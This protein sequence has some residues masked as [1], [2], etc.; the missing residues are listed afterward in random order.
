MRP[1]PSCLTSLLIAALAVPA[2][3]DGPARYRTRDA[4][5]ELHRVPDRLSIGLTSAEESR[6]SEGEEPLPASRAVVPFEVRE[7]IH[8][9]RMA[10]ITPPRVRVEGK[11]IDKAALD[12][13]WRER[14]GAALDTVRLDPGVEW[15][16]PAYR[17]A[18]TGTLLLPTP[19]VVVEVDPRLDRD[20]IEGALEGRLTVVRRIRGAQSQWILELVDPARD[21]LAVALELGD[22][23]WT[24]WAEPELIQEIRFESLPNDPLL[25][26]SWHIR[27]TGQGGGLA[28]ADAGLE[29]AWDVQ[30]GDGSVVIAV[31]DDGVQLDHPDLQSRIFVN[32]AE[33]AGNGSDDDGNGYVDDRHGWD[34]FE[35]DAVADPDLSGP[36]SHGT[37]VAGV[38]AAAGD[39]G[40]GGTGA[41]QNCRILPVRISSDTFVSNTVIGEA[42]RYAADFADVLNNSWGGGSPSSLIETAIDDAVLNG[43]G[44]LGAPT[45]FA[46][47]NSATGFQNLSLGL[48]AFGAGTYTIEFGFSKDGS[49]SAGLDKVW[50]DN[51]GFPDGTIETFESCTSLPAGWTNPGDDAG[52]WTMNQAEERASST[53]GGNCSVQSPTIG[54]GQYAGVQTTRF[55]D[56]GAS[57]GITYQMWA[58]TERAG[59]NPDGT[60][61]AVL[62]NCWDAGVLY[63]LAPDGFAYGPFNSLCGTYSNQ[64]NALMD[65][66]LSHPSSY[67]RTISV[68]AATNF[69]RRSDYSQW[70]TGIDFVAH[71]S[72]GSLGILA[73]DVTGSN[74]YDPSDYTDT[75]G[76]TSSATPLAAGIVGLLLTQE[77]NLTEAQVRTRLREATRDVGPVP[78]VAGFNTHY[79]YGMLDASLLIVDSASQIFSDGFE[80]GNTSAWN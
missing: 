49:A 78:Y 42:I 28:G 45:L 5:I 17:S 22:E 9:A 19:R 27:N 51:V 53:Y 35:N 36:G 25:G 11:H 2:L 23:P 72:G 55:I 14:T 30:K 80:S 13:L 1:L 46:N 40:I 34:F 8:G 59:A 76:G 10:T 54:H 15:A 31:I 26:Q 12:A 71:S 62:D 75:F 50:V 74:G 6:L 37:S 70:G 65:G 79:G 20:A 52:D 21:P 66:Q 29:Q 69:D 33:I 4:E 64:G 44:G 24:R 63:V 43:R 16:Y 47:G 7:T 77:P 73:T 48:V 58:S 56:P 18:A 61:P 60:G 39:N 67:H 32:T 38:A 41:C 57:G 3:A 68:G